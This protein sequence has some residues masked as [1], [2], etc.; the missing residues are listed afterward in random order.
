MLSKKYTENDV[1]NMFGVFGTIEECSVLRDNG[2]S[3]GCAF[4]TFSSKQSA[5]NASKTLHHS[6]T[7]EVNRENLFYNR[8]FFR[9]REKERV[10]NKF[11]SIK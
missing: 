9:V 10:K 8:N 11:L 2:Q 5:I 1:R 7:M 4:V 6:Q 3:K